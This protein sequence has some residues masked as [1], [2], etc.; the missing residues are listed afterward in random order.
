[1][2][3]REKKKKARLG[4]I[5]AGWW[6]TSNHMPVLAQRD[7][8][9]MV[10]VCRLGAD[11]LQ[12]VKSEFGFEHSTEDFRELLEIPDLDG[13]IVSSP[14]GMH[15]EHALAALEKG[16][17]VMCEK[18]LTT[19]A[20]DARE[21]VSS[22]DSR[23][24]HLLIPL[25][26]HHTPYVQE[27]R[28]RLIDGAVGEIEFV[29]CHM[30][31]PLRGLLTG[32][33]FDYTMGDMFM[34]PDSATWADPEVAGGGYGIS[35]MSHSAALTFW[36]T[37]LQPRRVAALTT[38]PGSRV[39]LYDA[40]TVEFDGGVIG[41]FSGAATIPSDRGFQLDIRIFGADGV[42][43]LDF[44]RARLQVLRNDGDH[45]ESHLEADAGA[46]ACDGPPNNFVDLILG[47]T[48]ENMTP[49]VVGMK[50][51][52]MVDAAYRSASTGQFV[53]V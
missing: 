11:E 4:F 50:A 32:G 38:A 21:L 45:Y 34:A 24:L 42:L 48:D 51:I 35:Q 46:Y 49:G 37:G 33:R 17:H 47:N 16:L 41:S 30:A 36:L 23:G 20:R 9:E 26:W 14:H 15:H 44:E 13:I 29:Q 31:S 52:E 28:Q 25:G 2:P 39:E 53:D 27:A 18:P 10:A 7:D 6:A 1:M 5:G 40:L 19:S 43:S 12:Q 3:E 8:V 22:A